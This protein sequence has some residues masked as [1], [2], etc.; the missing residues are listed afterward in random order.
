VRPL[1]QDDVADERHD[2]LA[3]RRHPRGHRPE[4]LVDPVVDDG[5]VQP[6]PWAEPL[7][8][9]RPLAVGDED[10]P[11]GVPQE[12]AQLGPSV[13]AG[14]AVVD[15]QTDARS[16][17]PECLPPG[18]AGGGVVTLVDQDELRLDGADHLDRWVVDV[19]EGGTPPAEPAPRDVPPHR[20]RREPDRAVRD[21]QDAGVLRR[22]PGGQRH[23]RLS[24]A[25][26]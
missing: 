1:G 9:F 20:G 16:V 15:V 12:S 8:G 2:E 6:V 22:R 26:S 11:V 24:P 19:A 18:K 4:Q 10:D 7:L 14:Q 21:R 17:A 5:Q 13:G 3:L 23:R 25:R